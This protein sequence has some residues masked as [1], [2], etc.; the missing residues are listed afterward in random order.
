MDSSIA[1]FQNRLSGLDSLFVGARSMPCA[2][3]SLKQI[4]PSRLTLV[5]ES[6]SN[7]VLCNGVAN[8]A[9]FQILFFVLY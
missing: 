8:F 7:F 4:L 9:I 1:L 6:K 2:I 3:V 5:T